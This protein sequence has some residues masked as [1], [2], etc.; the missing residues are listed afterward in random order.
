MLY[1]DIIFQHVPPPIKTINNALFH[2][3]KQLSYS[4]HISCCN[5]IV[6]CWTDESVALIADDKLATFKGLF[7][8]ASATSF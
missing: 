6:Y 5:I 2:F 7:T 1:Q 3:H 8:L 4:M